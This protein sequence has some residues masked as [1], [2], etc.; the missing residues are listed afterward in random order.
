MLVRKNVC[1]RG[2]AVL[3]DVF[4]ECPLTTHSRRSRS[5]PI[6]FLDSQ[7]GRTADHKGARK[8]RR[9][10]KDQRAQASHP[11]RHRRQL[12]ALQVHGADRSR[13]RPRC[14]EALAGEISLRP[15][16]M[17]TAATRVALVIGRR[18]RLTPSSKLSAATRR[19][20]AFRCC[21]AAGSSSNPRLDHEELP[22]CPRLLATHSRRRH[23]HHRRPL[24]ARQAMDVSNSHLAIKR[25]QHRRR[26]E[27]VAFV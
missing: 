22:L 17:P 20:R 25:R 2:E 7:S 15:S 4:T 13:R 1:L 9:R 19:P 5:N 26:E 8:A 11:D 21:P 18:K 10:Q 12:P 24:N 3:A 16:L 6:G 14:P 23:P 27:V